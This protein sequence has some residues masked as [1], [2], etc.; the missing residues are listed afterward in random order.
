MAIIIIITI[1]ILKVTVHLTSAINWL[2]GRKESL[3]QLQG[4]YG[5]HHMTNPLAEPMVI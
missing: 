5:I 1:I 3:C 2:P 4:D